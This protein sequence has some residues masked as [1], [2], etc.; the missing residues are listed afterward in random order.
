MDFSDL[1]SLV[2]GRLIKLQSTPG[3][4]LLAEG[5]AHTAHGKLS[6]ERSLTSA[7]PSSLLGSVCPEGTDSWVQSAPWASLAHRTQELSVSGEPAC[8]RGQE[9]SALAQS[10]THTPVT[11]TVGRPPPAPEAISPLS[12]QKGNRQN[13][14]LTGPH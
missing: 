13:T 1:L 8:Q 4:V 5:M 12:I 7:S 6:T 3:V 11:L 14:Q 10:F 2:G 9:F